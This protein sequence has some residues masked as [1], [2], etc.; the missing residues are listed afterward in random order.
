MTTQCQQCEGRADLFLCPTCQTYLRRQLTGL[1][2]L[3]GHLRDTAHG[4]TR[5]SNDTSRQLGFQSRT[6]IFDDRATRLIDDIGN[7]LGQ[8]ATQMAKERGYVISVPVNWHR[9]I[10][11][12]RHTSADYAVFLAA[13]VTELAADPDI[14]EL[15]ASLK[16]YIKRSLTLVNRRVPEQ[17]CGPCPATI[18]DHRHCDDCSRRDHECSTRLMAARGAIEVTCPGCGAVHRAE[19]L[20]NHLLARADDYRCT[21]P[22]L[23]RVLR[24]LGT[25]V[26]L[27]TL[28][29]WTAPKVGRLRPAGYLRPDNKRI[30]VDRHSDEDTPVYRVSDARKQHEESSKPGRVGRPLKGG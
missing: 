26:N 17:F 23:H 10:S 7:M 4:L 1:P 6:P 5:M 18:V 19:A 25:P 8:W 9:P 11:E 28:Y 2:T 12:Y 27:R 24:M 22:E 16:S 20:V 14:G 30:G 13:H 3:L 15:C 21:I 29:H